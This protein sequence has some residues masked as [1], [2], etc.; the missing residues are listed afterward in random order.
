[1]LEQYSGIVSLPDSTIK[2]QWTFGNGFSAQS[3]N[4][5]VTYSNT[6]NYN[7]QLIATNKLGC[8]DTSAFHCYVVPLPTAISVSNPVQIIS[9][10]STQLNMNYT[11][12]I[13]SYNWQP[14]QH[15]NCFT[16]PFP[17]A[18]PQFTTKYTVDIADRYGCTSR[19]F[20]TVQVLCN[21]QIFF[22]PNSFSP[23]GD[24]MN[25]IFYLRGTGL[26]RIKSLRVFDRW[27]EVVF[28]K[29]EVPVNNPSFGWDGT[30]KGRKAAAGVYVYQVE[31][32]CSNGDLLTYSGN[33]A[34]I[35]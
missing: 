8:A 17:I 11:G 20:V 4:P 34:L 35:L 12:P 6:G 32:I 21:G 2:W 7:I 3:Q 14:T 19:G 1:N 18:N 28:E 22:I 5:S 10:A 16:C 30:Y 15:L 26:F 27:G 13:V 9:G 33:I 29:T 24:G 31:I 25:D 23:N